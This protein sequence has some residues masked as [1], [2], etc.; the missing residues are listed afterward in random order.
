MDFPNDTVFELRVDPTSGR[1]VL[2]AEARALRPSDFK[3]D[4]VPFPSHDPVDCPFCPGNEHATPHELAVLR[5][6]QGAWQARV[7]P[8]K[9]P[10]VGLASDELWTQGVPSPGVDGQC[11]APH[12]VHEVIIESARHVRDWADL[13]REE[14]VD[15]LRLFRDRINNAYREHGMTTAILFKNVGQG[16]GASLEH[17]HSQLVVLPFAPQVLDEELRI[18]AEFYA[19]SGKCLMCD[20]LDKEI[21]GERFVLENEHFSAFCAYAGRQPYEMWIV[22]K[23]HGSRFTELADSH[24]GSLAE[25]LRELVRRLSA[26]IVEPAYNLVLHMAPMNDDRARAFHWHWELIPRTTS[27]AG[28]EWGTGM[29]INSVSPE[30]A[31]IRLR[32]LKPGEKLPIQ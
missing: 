27:L 19:S 16:A 21:Q 9:F 3:S 17:I 28:F 18:A 10:A 8:N 11:L 29:H 7:V 14:V 15:V 30:R 4:P 2:I 23:E 12:G 22:P 32:A 13:K 6:T 26:V 31:A 5:N 20:L 1:R 25:I 24:F